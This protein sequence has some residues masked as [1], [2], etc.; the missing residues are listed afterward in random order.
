MKLERVAITQLTGLEVINMAE[1]IVTNVGD[2][3]TGVQT[4]D[5]AVKRYVK[6]ITDAKLVYEK[7]SKNVSS[8]PFTAEV[9]AAD[10]S[11]DI[12]VSAYRRQLRVYE[13]DADPKKVQAFS[14]LDALWRTHK[15]LRSLNDKAQTSGIDNFLYDSKKEPYV[16]DNTALALLP[17]LDSIETFNAEFKVVVA[18]QDAAKASKEYFDNKALRKAL[19]KSITN[20]GNYVLAMAKAYP[21]KE[22]FQQLFSLL[23]VTRKKYGTLLAQRGGSKN[24]KSKTLEE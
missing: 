4:E 22:D 15:D 24:A 9:R 23:N 19:E 1:E 12:A 6:E 16:T 18:R 7:A 8:D 14:R 10:K 17:F 5:D 13:Y 20:Y 21:E 11:R 2:A 3:E